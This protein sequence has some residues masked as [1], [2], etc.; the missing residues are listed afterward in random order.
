MPTVLSFQEMLNKQAEKKR[1]NLFMLQIDGIDAWTV[2]AASLPK[3]GINAV[4]DQFL[5]ERS[6]SAGRPT[7]ETI[8]VTL[9]DPIAPSASQKVYEWIILIYDPVTGRMGY[10]SEYAKDIFLRMLGPDGTVVESWKLI[11]C[12]PSNTD[13][14]E[15]DMTIDSDFVRLTMT[16]TYDKAMII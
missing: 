1:Q 15:G 7:W 5:N 14:G 12:W 8:N 9:I 11:N 4:E 10:K 3:L 16:L 6:Y 13:F 2:R